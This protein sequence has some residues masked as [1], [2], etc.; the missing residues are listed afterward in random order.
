MNRRQLFLGLGAACACAAASPA[1]ACS[2]VQYRTAADHLEHIDVLFVGRAMGTTGS[3]FIAVTR[4]R[5]LHVLKGHPGR[6]AQVSHPTQVGAGCG[7]LMPTGRTMLVAASRVGGRL[8]TSSCSMP[9]FPISAYQ[10]ALRRRVRASM[11]LPA[12]AE[13]AVRLA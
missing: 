12:P 11:D 6:I 3:G 9:R 13:A 4:L 8:S 5:V 2:C 10:A 1:L 7:V